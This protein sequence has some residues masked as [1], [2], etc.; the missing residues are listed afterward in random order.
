MGYG[1]IEVISNNFSM[2][3][4]IHDDDKSSSLTI[5][6]LILATTNQPAHQRPQIYLR[7]EL[8]KKEAVKTANNS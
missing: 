5:P 7:V 2:A 1:L 6:N 4:V 3:K 8:F